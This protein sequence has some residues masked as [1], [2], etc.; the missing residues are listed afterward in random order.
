MHALKK[1]ALI[2]SEY[3]FSFTSNS[4]GQSR[5]SDTAVENTEIDRSNQIGHLNRDDDFRSSVGACLAKCI[6]R[7]PVGEQTHVRN[8]RREMRRDCRTAGKKKLRGQGITGG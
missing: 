2:E 7:R 4:R 8:N 5:Y 6:S 3:P 1:K